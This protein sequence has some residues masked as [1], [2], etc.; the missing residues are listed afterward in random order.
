MH[1]CGHLLISLSWNT[2]GRVDFKYA[3]STDKRNQRSKKW[4]VS[5]ITEEIESWKRGRSLAK[6][7]NY[8]IDEQKYDVYMTK[9]IMSYIEWAAKNDNYRL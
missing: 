2:F 5:L 9:S 4:K 1:E 6:R 7:L 3:C 8:S